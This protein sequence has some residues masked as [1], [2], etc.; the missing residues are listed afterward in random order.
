[1]WGGE[2]NHSIP[3]EDSAHRFIHC[4]IACTIWKYSH[5]IIRMCNPFMFDDRHGGKSL[6]EEIDRHSHMDIVRVML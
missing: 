1:M 4:P 3:L 6:C 5:N 2:R